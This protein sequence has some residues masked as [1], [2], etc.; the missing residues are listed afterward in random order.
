MS[1]DGPASRVLGGYHPDAGL[2]AERADQITRLPVPSLLRSL[3][4]DHLDPGY[5]A[6]AERRSKSARRLG[7]SQGL[8]QAV[9]ALLIAAVFAH[10]C[11]SLIVVS[12]CIPGSPHFQA[13][14]AMRR[15]RSRAR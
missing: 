3:L 5:A 12:Y 2:R 11:Q 15:K 1:G 13:E 9:G 7:V 8:W 4:T 10:V 6:A 14:S